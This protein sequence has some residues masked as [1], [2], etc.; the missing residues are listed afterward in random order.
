MLYT[1]HREGWA[2]SRKFSI[3]FRRKDVLYAAAQLKMTK[4][5]STW[6]T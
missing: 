5:D 2:D 6:V 4:R 1:A 3:L